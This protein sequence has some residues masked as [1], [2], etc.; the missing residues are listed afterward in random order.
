MDAGIECIRS[1][2]ADSTELGGTVDSG[3]TRGLAVGFR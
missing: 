3:G 2:F 1:K